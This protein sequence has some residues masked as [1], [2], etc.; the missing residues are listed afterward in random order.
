LR[1]QAAAKEYMDCWSDMLV[2][3]LH[4]VVG[5]HVSLT[6]TVSSRD[7]EGPRFEPVW[8]HFCAGSSGLDIPTLYRAGAQSHARA[9]AH[10]SGLYAV[11]PQRK[12][13]LYPL[14][15]AINVMYTLQLHMALPPQRSSSFRSNP[16]PRSSAMNSSTLLAS[17]SGT[18]PPAF[19]R[20]VSVSSCAR[21]EAPVSLIEAATP[22]GCS[23]Q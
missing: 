4:G 21:R 9:R 20:C 15:S 16:A 14:L 17:P 5:Y 23:L 2:T 1:S 10:T 12:R 11:Y 22:L 19:S 3:R 8:R 6:R 13:L 7:A 18:A